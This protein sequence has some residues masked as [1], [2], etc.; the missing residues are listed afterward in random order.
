MSVFFCGQFLVVFWCVGAVPGRRIFTVGYVTECLEMLLLARAQN[1]ARSTVFVGSVNRVSGLNLPQETVS[2][3][4]AMLLSASKLRSPLVRLHGLYHKK[5]SP[6]AFR[7]W[8][9]V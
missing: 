9:T 3:A 8:A 5:P 1:I 4:L 2:D 7:D 6:T